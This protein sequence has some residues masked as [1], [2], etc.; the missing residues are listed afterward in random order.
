ML[1]RWKPVASRIISTP[2][3]RSAAQLDAVLA[4]FHVESNPR[5]RPGGGVTWCNIFT[6]DWSLAM[7]AEIPHWVDGKETTAN[8]LAGWL[9]AHWTEH[10]PRDAQGEAN[11]GRPCVAVAVNRAGPG[12]IAPVRPGEW[13]A[14]GPWVCNVGA[15][16]VERSLT[17]ARFGR[18][19]PRFYS[20]R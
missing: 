19:E 6:W 13:K 2:D 9:A 4:Q 7:G 10:G 12:H 15:R 17:A 8:I 16:N 14:G 3:A 20:S 1:E 18:L 11:A 5:Y